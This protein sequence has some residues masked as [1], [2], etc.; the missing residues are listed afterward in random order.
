MHRALNERHAQ[1]R[2]AFAQCAAQRLGGIG[3]VLVIAVLRFGITAFAVCAGGQHHVEHL[4]LRAV[5]ARRTDADDVF[6]AILGEQLPGINADRRHAHTA[7]HH[8]YR[9]TLIRAGVAQHA[10]HRG[11]KPR[12]FQ[13]GLGN[14][15]CAQRVSG[16]EHGFCKIARGGRIVWG[17]HSFFSFTV[18]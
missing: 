11:N 15:F 4:G 18:G 2:R 14:E 8:G 13:K 16:H 17:R 1:P 6:H 5:R 12:A 10:A 7:S 9:H 3:H